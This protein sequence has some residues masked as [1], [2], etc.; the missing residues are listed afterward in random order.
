[1][2]KFIG[3]LLHRAAARGTGELVFHLN[4]G[5]IALSSDELA[6]RAEHAASAL[7]SWGILPGDRIGLL[8]PNRPEWA[9]WAFAAWLVGA[10]LVPIQFPV[11]VRDPEAFR[12]RTRL[13]LE[14]AGCRLVVAA[15][16]FVAGVTGAPAHSWDSRVPGVRSLPDVDPSG[17]AVVQ[18]TSGSTAEPKGVLVSHV[19]V[20]AQMDALSAASASR[21]KEDRAFGWVPFFHDLGLFMFLLHP[22]A[23]LRA[24]DLLPTERFVRDPGEWL[25]AAGRTGATQLDAPY[26]SWALAVRAAVRN[27]EHPDLSQV[28]TAWL[29]AEPV[30]PEGM[31]AV[32]ATTAEW[33]L[34]PVAWGNTYG[35]AEAVAGVTITPAGRGLQFTDVDRTILAQEGRAVPPKASVLR[36]LGCGRPVVRTEVRI[37]SQGRSQPD[38]SVGEVQFR[39]ESQ[40]TGYFGL[41]EGEGFDGTWLHTGDQGFI[42]AGE[43]HVT[44][45]QKDMLIVNGHN[46]HPEDFEWAAGRVPGVRPGRA[47]AFTVEGG[48]GVILLAEPVDE[49]ADEQLISAIS[50]ATGDALGAASPM[51]FLVPVGTLQKTTSG[52]LRRQLMREMHSLGQVPVW[53]GRGDGSRGQ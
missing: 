15:P 47:V 29:A 14:A 34:D 5:Q 12:E 31:E 41:S 48:D 1:V 2:V 45:R 3:D 33:G 53:V 21:A 7:L 30:D 51:V 20:L 4:E 25:R 16:E 43:L 38:G 49:D 36:V 27:A 32:V 39:G 18:F 17:I 28:R 10:S 42:L 44:G 35:L 6:E 37:A 22:V 52:K 11:R 26:S 50:A 9:V 8:G 13:V 19:A 46:Y 24:G 40:M 23:S